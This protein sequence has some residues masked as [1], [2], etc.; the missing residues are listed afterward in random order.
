MS[1]VAMDV[2]FVTL[3]VFLSLVLL[4]RLFHGVVLFMFPPVVPVLQKLHIFT[5]NL[6]FEF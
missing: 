1:K 2:M 6:F 3:C 4:L 5:W